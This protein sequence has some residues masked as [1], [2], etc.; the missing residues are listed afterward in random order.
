MMI[1][2]VGMMARMMMNMIINLLVIM[3]RQVLAGLEEAFT[4]VCKLCNSE[5]RQKK[6][7]F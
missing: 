5:L 6:R 1:G 3:G 4:K 2:L 7:N